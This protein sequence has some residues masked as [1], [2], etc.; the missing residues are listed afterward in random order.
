MAAN[1]S[2]GLLLPSDVIELCVCAVEMLQAS[3]GYRL[4]ERRCKRLLQSDL[5]RERA[6]E[7]LSLLS[8]I[9]RRVNDKHLP[10]R[11]LKVT[12]FELS[13]IRF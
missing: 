2:M 13:E 11:E 8:P 10:N 7:C 5:Y 1:F 6:C 9:M 12:Y 4:R 3:P